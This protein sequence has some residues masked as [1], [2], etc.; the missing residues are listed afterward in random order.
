MSVL[1]HGN[2]L[3]EGG[4]LLVCTLLGPTG[5][6]WKMLC[7]LWTGAYV[8]G[9]PLPEGETWQGRKEDGEGEGRG[10]GEGGDSQSW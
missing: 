2:R 6:E 3:Q 10:R 7:V 4:W 1:G 9:V 8:Q 5:K